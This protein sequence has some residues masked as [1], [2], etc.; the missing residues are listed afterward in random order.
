MT[1][2]SEKSGNGLSESFDATRCKP[3]RPSWTPVAPAKGGRAQAA[4]RDRPGDRGQLPQ[5]ARGSHR[6]RPDAARCAMD[7][8][9]AAADRRTDHRAGHPRQSPRRLAAAPQ[10]SLSEAA[11]AREEDDGPPSPNAPFGNIARLKREYLA[12]FGLS[13]FSA[14]KK[15]PHGG[16]DDETVPPPR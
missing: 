16:K 10:A 4:D 14:V 11:G 12:V 3:A 6:R 15:I 9:V 8:P 2:L 1:Y 13:G 7:Q 5:G